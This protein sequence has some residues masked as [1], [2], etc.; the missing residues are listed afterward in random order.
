MM[1]GAQTWSYDNPEGWDRW[2][3]GEG[4]MRERMYILWL[5]HVG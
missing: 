1:P 4:F 3:V 5:S 2:E